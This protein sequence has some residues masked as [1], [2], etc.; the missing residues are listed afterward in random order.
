MVQGIQFTGLTP[1]QHFG[2]V[3][4]NLNDNNHYP[5]HKQ[6]KEEELKEA[7]DSPVDLE[8]MTLLE[9]KR[10]WRQH[11]LTYKL[12]NGVFSLKDGKSEEKLDKKKSTKRVSEEEGDLKDEDNEK[13][14]NSNIRSRKALQLAINDKRVP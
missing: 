13:V 10:Y 4:Q 3:S 7:P 11:I 14:Q 8:S 9:K 12:E 6:E 1:R 2:L 5:P